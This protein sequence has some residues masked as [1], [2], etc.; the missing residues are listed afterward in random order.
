MTVGYT[1][2]T[3]LAK[4]SSKKHGLFISAVA[5]ASSCFIKV[6]EICLSTREINLLN[7]QRSLWYLGTRCSYHSYILISFNDIIVIT[8]T[9]QM[10]K[11]SYMELW[12]SANYGPTCDKEPLDTLPAAFNYWSNTDNLENNATHFLNNYSGYGNAGGSG[13][14]YFKT[15]SDDQVLKII[16]HGLTFKFGITSTDWSAPLRWDS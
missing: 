4:R 14:F 12:A 5:A 1:E 13:W 8:K 6:A 16:T 15:L 11:Y 9:K 10:K 7:H 2:K 3:E